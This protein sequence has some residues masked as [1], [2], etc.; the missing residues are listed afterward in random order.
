MNQ[1]K[2]NSIP[3]F[4]NLYNIKQELNY[5]YKQNKR[6]I[7]SDIFSILETYNIPNTNTI[8]NDI[9]KFQK[10]IIQEI[11]NSYNT[12]NKTSAELHRKILSIETIKFTLI[13]KTEVQKISSYELKIIFITIA[14]LHAQGR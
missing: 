5:D 8:R 2:K 10:E 7:T 3:S 11:K 4:S 6:V 12:N 14:M 1:S 13:F 9:E